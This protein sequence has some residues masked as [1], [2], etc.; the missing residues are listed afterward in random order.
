MHVDHLTFAAGPDGLKAEVDRLSE[1]LGEEFKDGGFHPRFGTRNNILP[2]AGGRYLEV[3]EVLDHP[4]ADKA[5]FG[6]AVRQRSEQGGGWLSW[7]LSVDE[8]TMTQIEER[9]DRKAVPGSRR[10][11]DGRLLEWRQIGL[12]GVMVDAQLPYFLLWE[13]AA[14]ILP[15]ALAGSSELT[16]LEISG[17]RERLEEWL[18]CEVGDELDGVEITFDSPRGVPSIDAVTFAT[19]N[20]GLVRI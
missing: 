19:R 7:I 9:L 20:R 15:S 11:P 16:K 17:S 13:S 8:P 1:L 6:Q 14:H 2:L 3:V 4:A 5:I 12:K 18:G 10:F